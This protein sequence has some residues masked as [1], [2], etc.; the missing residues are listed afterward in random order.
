M[1]LHRHWQRRRPG[2]LHAGV[3]SAGFNNV[4]A[5][6]GHGPWPGADGIVRHEG[7]DGGGANTRVGVLHQHGEQRDADGGLCGGHQ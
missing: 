7:C 6:G 3:R 2:E 4:V 5:A 1:D